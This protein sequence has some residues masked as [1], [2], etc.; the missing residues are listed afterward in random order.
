MLKN[1]PF[2]SQWLSRGVPF[3]LLLHIGS[4]YYFTR[5]NTAAYYQ[6]AD[7]NQA[8]ESDEDEAYRD[9]GWVV[10]LVFLGLLKIGAVL[11]MYNVSD[12]IHATVWTLSQGS[13]W[14]TGVDI[15]NFAVLPLA[16]TAVDHIADISTAY[17]GDIN[18]SWA[19]L[20][21]S[22]LQTC[23][24]ARPLVTL[25]TYNLDRQDGRMGI[26]LC[27]LGIAVCLSLST[28][29]GQFKGLVLLLAYSMLLSLFIVHPEFF[30]AYML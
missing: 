15:V 28:I 13:V 8:P 27:F 4:S 20:C 22:M 11:L 29:S 3:F 30:E 10:C 26:I 12:H 18:R 9:G 21:Q 5:W 2:D 23:F 14:T 19:N 7:K 17:K 16:V 1:A 24:F 25:A 6:V